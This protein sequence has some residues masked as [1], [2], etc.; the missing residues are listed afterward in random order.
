M[1]IEMHVGIDLN[2]AVSL[3]RILSLCCQR[4]EKW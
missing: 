4:R 2:K 1:P 3:T